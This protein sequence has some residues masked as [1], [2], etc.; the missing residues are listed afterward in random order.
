MFDLAVFHSDISGNETPSWVN[1]N[2]QEI[3][4]II[5]LVN[6]IRLSDRSFDAP[7]FSLLMSHPTDRSV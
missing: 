2:V 3:R 1:F 6:E 5:F 4:S 7:P